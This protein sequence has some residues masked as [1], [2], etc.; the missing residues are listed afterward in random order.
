MSTDQSEDSS[1]FPLTCAV[2]QTQDETADLGLQ[3]VSPD[4]SLPESEDDWYIHLHDA[5]N[6]EVWESHGVIRNG[7]WY[8][9][10]PDCRPPEA[11]PTASDDPDFDIEAFVDE[12]R[13]AADPADAYWPNG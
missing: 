5:D 7:E 13:E 2:C 11:L 12:L 3:L 6:M 10:C 9:F 1:L 8:A 4:E